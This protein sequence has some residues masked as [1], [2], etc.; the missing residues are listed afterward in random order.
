MLNLHPCKSFGLAIVKVGREGE[1][2]N[3]LFLGGEGHVEEGPA[4][5]NWG[6]EE[7]FG[8]KSSGRGQRWMPPL[9]SLCTTSLLNSGRISD[10]EGF[11]LRTTTAEYTVISSQ[12]QIAS[13]NNQQPTA[14]CSQQQST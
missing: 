6:P 8:T 7:I 3:R 9:L 10:S 4:P 14:T 5:I 1:R 11:L 12:Q 13:K 2:V